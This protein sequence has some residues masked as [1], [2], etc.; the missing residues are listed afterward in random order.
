MW[1]CFMWKPA[2]LCLNSLHCSP[3]TRRSAEPGDEVGLCRIPRP[4]LCV[5]CAF[6]KQLE[7]QVIIKL[8]FQSS[9]DIVHRLTL[10]KRWL[11]FTRTRQPLIL[12][13]FYKS[14]GDIITPGSTIYNHSPSIRE[15]IREP[16][17][18]PQRTA[19]VKQGDFRKH[20]HATSYIVLNMQS[21][22]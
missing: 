14:G 11:L 6:V 4:S 1:L 13:L 22:T 9:S 18:N 21:E 15:R 19:A 20:K 5:S 7:I 10:I 17:I 2:S 3:P 8:W 16:Y 12:P